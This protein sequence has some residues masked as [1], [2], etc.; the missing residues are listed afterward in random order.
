[1]AWANKRDKCFELRKSNMLFY[2]LDTRIPLILES[3][4]TVNTL[5]LNLYKGTLTYGDFNSQRKAFAREATGKLANASSNM[6]KDQENAQTTANQA[7][8]QNKIEQS[9]LAI[10][11][12]KAD[13]MQTQ[14]N[15]I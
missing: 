8:R 15:N 14:A 10:E 1:M 9:R 2:P 5:I 13:A 6:A 4:D 12:Q 7:K 11:Q 3:W